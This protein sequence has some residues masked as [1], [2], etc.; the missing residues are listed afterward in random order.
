MHSSGSIHLVRYKDFA[1]GVDKLLV[2]RNDRAIHRFDT[3]PHFYKVV[4]EA[5]D[6][7]VDKARRAPDLLP[8]QEARVKERNR[9]LRA[10]SDNAID[11]G[12]EVDIPVVDL[13]SHSL[14][15]LLLLEWDINPCYRL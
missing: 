5:K 14:F 1:S 3:V 2:R 12:E 15:G 9:G 4:L 8:M 13:V 7:T 11:D 6:L 10:R